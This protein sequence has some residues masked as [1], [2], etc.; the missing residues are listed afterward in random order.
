MKV[1]RKCHEDAKGSTPLTELRE[2]QLTGYKRGRGGGG[3]LSKKLGELIRSTTRKRSGSVLTRK[4]N[5]LR[6]DRRTKKREKKEK[7]KV[8][9]K[10]PLSSFDT[11]TSISFDALFDG[12]S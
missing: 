9:R 1:K 2:N 8:F 7:K 5:G 4:K 6:F 12:K 3:S 10:N 11:F